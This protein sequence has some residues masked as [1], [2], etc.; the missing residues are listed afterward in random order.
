MGT[1]FLN[2]VVLL[3]II[4]TGQKY[5]DAAANLPEFTVSVKKFF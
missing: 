2:A 3:A 1:H 5:S 4:T